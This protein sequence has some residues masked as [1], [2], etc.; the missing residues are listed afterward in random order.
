MVSPAPWGAPSGGLVACGVALDA[1]GAVGSVDLVQDVAPRARPP[2]RAPGFSGQGRRGR[3]P[4]RRRSAR[5]E[6]G[7][8]R[9]LGH[10][11]AS[12]AG[13]RRLG[14]AGPR[15]GG[16]GRSGGAPSRAGHRTTPA[17][18]RGR[19]GPSDCASNRALSHDTRL[20]CTT[21]R[22][23]SDR[24]SRR[25]STSA[26]GETAS[27]STECAVA[28]GTRDLDLVLRGHD[29]PGADLRE[30]G[31]ARRARGTAGPAC[32]M[33]RGAPP[34]TRGPGIGVGRWLHSCAILTYMAP[35]Q[36]GSA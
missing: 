30:P 29:V 16:H 27:R 20:T 34:E 2:Q 26:Q 11:T 13:R 36:G 31:H 17:R 9:L 12:L 28:R 3:P 22:R 4:S 18:A 19:D 1:S 14:L 21:P 7:P 35:R 25:G 8:F 5:G 6:G 23:R 24:R 33:E 10:D 32:E 15:P